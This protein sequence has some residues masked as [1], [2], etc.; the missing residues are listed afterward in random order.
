MGIVRYHRYTGELWDDLDLEALVDELSDFFLQSGFGG[1]EPGEL[2]EDAP[3]AVVLKQLER[4]P[5]LLAHVGALAVQA[6]DPAPA[7]AAAAEFILE[8]LYAQKK[9]GRS[10]DRGFVAVERPAETELDLERLERLR[11]MKKQVN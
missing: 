4:I 10:D 9:I 3:A 11:R 5:G 8:G 1:D 7:R 6:T 2:D